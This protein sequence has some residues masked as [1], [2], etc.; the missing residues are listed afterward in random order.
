MSPL[1]LEN[2]PGSQSVQ[3][4]VSLLKKLPAGHPVHWVLP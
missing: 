4:P 2:E 1:V 3:T